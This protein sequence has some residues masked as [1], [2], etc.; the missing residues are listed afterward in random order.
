MYFPAQRLFHLNYDLPRTFAA[1]GIFAAILAVTQARWNPAST[2]VS[3]PQIMILAGFAAFGLLAALGWNRIK[4]LLPQG[5][6]TVSAQ[7]DKGT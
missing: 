2:W 4:L 6:A 7:M 3:R 5:R 1:F